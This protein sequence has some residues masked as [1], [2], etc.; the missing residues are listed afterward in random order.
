VLQPHD[1][2]KWKLQ[3]EDLPTVMTRSRV[4]MLAAVQLSMV[5]LPA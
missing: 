5:V 2:A 4:P 1:V 3:L